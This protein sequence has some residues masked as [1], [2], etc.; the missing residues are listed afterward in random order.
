[1]L[2]ELMESSMHTPLT[3]H[4]EKGRRLGENVLTLLI[5]GE[6]VTTLTY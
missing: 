2:L 3:L 5:D 4:L 6:F 1:M